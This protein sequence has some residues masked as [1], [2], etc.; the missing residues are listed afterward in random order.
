MEEILKMSIK[1]LERY[2]IL[3]H[4]QKKKLSQKKAAELLKISDRQV[5]N[6]LRLK[7]EERGPKA[8]ISKKR[9]KSIL[10]L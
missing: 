7:V 1:E 2:K 5:R 10:R 6:L 3:S 8:L 9:G 4:V